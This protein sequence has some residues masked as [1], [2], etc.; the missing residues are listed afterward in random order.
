MDLISFLVI[1]VILAIFSGLWRY[2]L[3]RFLKTQRTPIAG[4]ESTEPQLRID[5]ET[6]DRNSE[7]PS[8][9]R[10]PKSSMHMLR[11]KS[12][13]SEKLQ[14]IR[15]EREVEIQ[16]SSSINIKKTFPLEIT[17]RKKGTIE[18]RNGQKITT[19]QKLSFESL[20]KEP[21]I[22]VELK[23]AEDEFKIGKK[24]EIR[25]L[26]AAPLVF[27]FLVTPLKA[28][29]CILTIVFSIVEKVITPEKTTEKV[30]ADKIVNPE[31]KEKKIERLETRKIA[32]LQIIE[33]EREIRS[34]DIAVSVKSLFGF[35]AS[36]LNLAKY[37]IGFAISGL[38]YILTV[39]SGALKGTEA[40][41]GAFLTLAPVV[42]VPVADV[43]K[44]KW[45]KKDKGDSE[46][47][48]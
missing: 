29:D 2:G 21:V 46:N 36:Q 22:S 7:T 5:T 28:E 33:E 11:S 43:T 17:I 39:A 47:S 9:L 1:F 18:V 31:V 23:F 25:K 34:I 3:D 42:G 48:S 27:R 32:P 38:V 6:Y 30:I 15:V 24:K 16:Y 19:I 40:I 45:L 44:W 10:M 20:E 37:S 8:G 26:T 41:L 35:T 14:P 4:T 13:S 12:S